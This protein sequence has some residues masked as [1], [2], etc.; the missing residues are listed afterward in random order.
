MTTGLALILAACGSGAATDS[1]PAPSGSATETG[2]S[3][4]AGGDLFVVAT[5]SVL[6]DIVS[7]VVGDA[8]TVEVIMGP[9]ADPHDFVPSPRQVASI[10]NADLVVA[11]GLGLEE[12]LI[13]VLEAAEAGGANVLELAD[14]LDPIPFG[15]THG[16]GEGEHSGEESA[17]SEEEGAHGDEDPHF[18]QDPVRVAEAVAIVGEELAAIDQSGPWQERAGAYA[19]E[20]TALHDEIETLLSPIPPEARKIV[21]NHEAFGYFAD[22]YGFEIIGTVIPGGSTL[23]EPSAADIADL[24]NELR[25]EGVTAIFAE[26]T[27]PT[28]LAET[29]AAELGSEVEVFELYSDSLG[30]PGS[31]ADTYIGMI[32]SNA[33]T[34][35]TALG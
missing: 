17:H 25:E 14:R 19:A 31:G 16:H 23:A 24:V 29:V 18:W 35:A 4:R 15:E 3:G 26:N 28:V 27:N 10:D 30:E 33:E 32:R 8:A 13:D 7:N 12:A 2:L 34:V 21:T 11:N 20:V 1:V 9:G 22:R 5:T 6:G